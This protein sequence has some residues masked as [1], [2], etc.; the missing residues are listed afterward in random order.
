MLKHTIM[1]VAVAG[2]VFA[3]APAAR[4]LTVDMAP[5][6]DP[7]NTADTTGYGAV[8]YDYSIGKTEVTNAQYAEFLNLKA[9]SDPHNLFGWLSYNQGWEGILRSGSDGSYTYATIQDMANLPVISINWFSTLRFANWMTNGQGDGDTETGSYDMSQQPYPTRLP[10]AEYVTPNEDEWY[11]AAYYKGGSTSAGYWDYSTQS[12]TVPVALSR[13]LSGDSGVVGDGRIGGEGGATPVLSGNYGRISSLNGNKPGMNNVNTNGGP[14]AYGTYDQAGNVMEFLEGIESYDLTGGGPEPVS[15]S[16]GGSY[17]G[18]NSSASHR[19][20]RRPTE[21]D[22]DLG[23]RVAKLVVVTDVPGDLDDN[24]TVDLAD[25][26]IFE[27]QF[28]SQAPGTY[29]ADF[30]G[31][32]DVDLDDYLVMRDNFGTVAAAPAAA[33]TPEPATMT[34]LAI[35]GML[36]MR[37]RRKA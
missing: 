16:R 18:T 37:R 28:G 9:A 34:V 22:I 7:G 17:W 31:D 27:L 10:A 8:S 2:L 20:L 26:G 25:V 23:F 29:T 4:A 3:L 33:A 36:V 24:G 13:V 5:I 14:S 6:G 12:D 32:Q 11:K 15:V 35:G 19:Q 21:P 1:F 30:D